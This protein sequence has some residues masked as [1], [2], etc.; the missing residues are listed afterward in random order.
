MFIDFVTLMLINLSAGFASLALGLAYNELDPWTMP[1]LMSSFI[2]LVTGFRMVFTWPL[3][4]PYNM[5]FGEMSVLAGTLFG[6]IALSALAN[7]P[8]GPLAV[9]GLLAALA[10]VTIGWR[11]LRLRLT[12]SP[13][14]SCTG[15][16][17]S[18][19]GGFLTVLSFVYTD[20][21][22]LRWMAATLL[23]VAA[24]IWALVGLRACA[25]HME[26][27]ADWPGQTKPPS[28]P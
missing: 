17:A 18:G 8:L 13:A 6:G 9:Y 28:K 15:F 26:S 25:E 16:T 27:F 19:V 2:A 14:L 21:A 22:P 12:R 3:P 5:A 24:L 10:A 7:W 11:I 20:I 23:L 4:G 1:L